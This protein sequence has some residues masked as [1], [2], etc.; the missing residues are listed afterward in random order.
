MACIYVAGM[1]TTYS[2][3]GVIAG[4]TGSIFGALLQSAWMLGFLGLLFLVLSLGQ[5]GLFKIQLPVAIQSKLMLA[6]SASNGMGVFL[7][8]FISGLIVSPCVGPVIAG[9]LAFVFDS[10]SPI[11]GL[12]YFL[13]FSMG[14]G[15]LFLLIGGFSGIVNRIPRSGAW[16]VRVNQGLAVLLLAASVYYGTLWAKRVGIVTRSSE[17]SELTWLTNEE[18]ARQ[19]AQA[20]GRVLV[21]DFTADWC[22][23]CHVIEKN[24]FQDPEVTKKLKETVLL[25][26]DLTQNTTKS[27]EISGRYEVRGLPA[28]V[29]VRPD[30]SMAPSRVTG[31]LSSREFLKLLVQSELRQIP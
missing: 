11:V 21:I 9:I 30:G 24:V 2:I 26:I 14:L 18:E 16:M 5:L 19:R 8:G 23:A 20:D 3:M 22:E 17:I 7:M 6:G 25:R 1:C 29:F 15:V 31:V 4:M 13:S 12:L 27:E 28:I 10:S